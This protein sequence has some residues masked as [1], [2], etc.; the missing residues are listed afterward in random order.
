MFKK[1]VPDDQE[2]AELERIRKALGMPEEPVGNMFGW[3]IS[4]IG[5]IVIA[6]FMALIAF[7]YWQIGH[8]DEDREVPAVI[9]ELEESK[10]QPVDS[11]ERFHE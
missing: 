7:R 11:L 3:R 6:G 8:F 5:F 10:A 1:Q 9:Q 2:K 4:L